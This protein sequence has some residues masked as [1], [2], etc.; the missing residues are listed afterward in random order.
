[1]L[2]PFTTKVFSET[3]F[4]RLSNHDNNFGNT[5]AMRPCFVF[6]VVVVFSERS[7]F[8]LDP[9][10]AIKLQQNVFVFLDNRI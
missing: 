4:M 3:P 2:L 6:V 9:K 8:N 10:N 1:M 7:K 5:S